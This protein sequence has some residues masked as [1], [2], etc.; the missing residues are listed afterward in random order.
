[1][2]IAAEVTEVTADVTAVGARVKVEAVLEALLIAGRVARVG[3]RRREQRIEDQ[4]AADGPGRASER[5][6]PDRL[7]IPARGNGTAVHAATGVVVRRVVA[8]LRARLEGLPL[9]LDLALLRQ[10]TR[11]GRGGQRRQLRP[12]IQPQR[13]PRG[14]DV[15]Q[16][17]QRRL[18][19]QP[20]LVH[21][22]GPLQLR[23][24]GVV[25]LTRVGERL[26]DRGLIALQVHQLTAE[27]LVPPLGLGAGVS[28]SLLSAALRLLLPPEAEQDA[29]DEDYH[30]EDQGGHGSTLPGGANAPIRPVH[31]FGHHRAPHRTSG[32]QPL[33]AAARRSRL[34]S[35]GK[36]NVSRSSA[37]LTSVTSVKPRWAR[38]ARTCCTKSSGTEAPEL[39]PTVRASASHSSWISSA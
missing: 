36:E 35:C 1:T 9:N 24:G 28:E 6:L 31:L 37:V 21:T 10:S 13:H 17:F 27:S 8:R 30:E 15:R 18:L 11:T 12:R 29:R 4:H 33:A 19:R 22:V 26:L 14:T 20:V 34:S 32:D 5:R 23:P 25:P 39:S 38:C 3:E 16:P 7:R 2:E